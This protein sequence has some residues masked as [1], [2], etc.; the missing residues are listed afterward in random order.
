MF[1]LKPPAVNALPR[2]PKTLCEDSLKDPP[3]YPPSET[4]AHISRG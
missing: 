4:L 2:R 3:L 1:S